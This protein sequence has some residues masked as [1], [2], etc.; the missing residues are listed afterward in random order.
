MS[1]R[2]LRTFLITLIAAGF[3][4]DSLEALEA[5]RQAED[6]QTATAAAV[7]P[8]PVTVDTSRTLT[9]NGPFRGY[10][11]QAGGDQ[12]WF[13]WFPENQNPNVV[14]PDDYDNH[15]VPRMRAMKLPFVRKFIH[16]G[17]FAPTVN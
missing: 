13:P 17:Y 8:V 2:S 12:L 10:G 1:A 14:V 3:G 9:V 5:P 15:I 4:A 6:N 7:A 16:M 11:A